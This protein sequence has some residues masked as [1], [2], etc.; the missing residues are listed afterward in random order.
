MGNQFE[1]NWTTNN[2]G[3]PLLD[4]EV[5]RYISVLPSENQ[6]RFAENPFYC[7]MHFGM[8]TA[9]AREWG[10]GKETPLDF[11]IKSINPQ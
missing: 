7:F 10:T 8:N 2:N 6:V 4:D 5:K 11:N 3:Y 1:K 9:T